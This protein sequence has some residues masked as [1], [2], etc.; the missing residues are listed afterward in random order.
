MSRL[1]LEMADWWPQLVSYELR[2][3]VEFTAVIDD[4]EVEF[5]HVKG[6]Y[7]FI[8]Y[9]FARD[10]VN[11]SSEIISFSST[12]SSLSFQD[13]TNLS[14]NRHENLGKALENSMLAIN[15]QYVDK[16]NESI[17]V[18][19]GDEVVIILPVSGC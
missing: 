13:L 2:S 19:P 7:N 14:K 10:A 3:L 1:K 8:Y 4:F 6:I 12:S 15:M 17:M 11:I 18:K 9:A 16:D 5:H